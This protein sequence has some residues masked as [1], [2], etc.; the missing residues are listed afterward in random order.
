MMSSG[1]SLVLAI[2]GLYLWK[3]TKDAEYLQLALLCVLMPLV[4]YFEYATG[5]IIVRNLGDSSMVI[6]RSL[7]L[8]S[9][10]LIVTKKVIQKGSR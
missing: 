6:I 2:I 8:V 3:K 9:F 7:F 10:L 5:N 1:V 4:T